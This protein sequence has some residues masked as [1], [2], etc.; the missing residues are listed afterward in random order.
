MKALSALLVLFCVFAPLSPP[1]LVYIFFFAKLLAEC[2]RNA[3]PVIM[4]EVFHWQRWKHFQILF[5]SKSIGTTIKYK[6]K[7][8]STVLTC[9]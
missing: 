8:M 1:F 9:C 2:C 4:L 7:S 6:S 3:T 5:L